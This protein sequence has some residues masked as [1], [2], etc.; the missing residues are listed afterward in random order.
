MDSRR[1]A[2][3]VPSDS[4]RR[5]LVDLTL[6]SESPSDLI[7]EDASHSDVWSWG[8]GKYGRLA[9]GTIADAS[10]P[11]P[12]AMSSSIRQVAAGSFVTAFLVGA[13]TLY[14]SGKDING[15]FAGTSLPQQKEGEDYLSPIPIAYFAK[16]CLTQV[17]VGETMCCAIDDVGQ[18]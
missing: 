7:V 1:K 15:L 5:S 8:S 12:V 2:V 11:T 3:S 9:L 6:S 18:L 10:V 14:M 13:G 4:C 17:A 16:T